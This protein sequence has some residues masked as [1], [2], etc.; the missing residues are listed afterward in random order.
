MTLRDLIARKRDGGVLN[1]AEWTWFARGVAAGS[2]PDYQ[3]SAFLM[4][5]VIRGLT[6]SETVALTD[7]MLHTGSTLKLDHLSVPRIDKHSTGGVGDKVSIVLAPLVAACGVA[8]PM[9]SGRG[10]GHTGGTLDKLEAIPGFSTRMSLAAAAK[11]VERIGCVMMGQTDEIAP[12]D[13]KLYAMRDA[14]GTVA[15]M[16]LIA[17]SIMSKKLAEGLTGLVLD[18]K[19]GIGA[20]LPTLEE[21]LALAKEMVS[22]GAHHDCPVVVILSNMDFPLGRESGNASEIHESVDALKGGG[23]A[24]LRALTLRLGAEMLLLGG[25]ERELSAATRRLEKALDSG[26]ALEKFRD[27]VVAQGGDPR[28]CD[29][30]A[31]VLPQPKIREQYV[32]RR[33]GVVRRMNALTIG[34]GITE[35]G[36]GRE[37]MEDTLDHSVGFTLRKFPGDQVNAGDVLATINAADAAGV[38]AG[39]AALDEAVVVGDEPLI[40]PPLISHRVTSRG[41]EKLG[42]A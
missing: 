2:F 27:L 22:L 11:Q 10:L 36:G 37:T 12:A 8:V 5:C 29:D 17:A 38:A 25:V 33:T 9:V 35:L 18:V 40:L 32:A 39:K 16:P 23:P 14:T 41:V 28:V 34:R 21:E 6:S 7:A 13:R 4:A 20:F 15:A 19:T 24:D 3:V 1:D 30:P 31:G 26:A 42:G